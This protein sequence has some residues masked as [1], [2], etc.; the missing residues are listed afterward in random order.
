MVMLVAGGLQAQTFTSTKNPR[1]DTAWV[2]G[3]AFANMGLGFL[4]DGRM[5]ILGASIQSSGQVMGQGVITPADGNQALYITNTPLS[6]SGSLTGVTVTKILDSLTGPPP[7][8]VVVNDTVYVQDRTAFYRVISLN[9][10]G[11]TAKSKNAVRIINAPTLD[12]TFV[13]LRGESGHQYV[14]SPVY[15]NGRFYGA[16]S[17]SIKTGGQSDAPPTS[18]YSGTLLSWAKDSIVPINAPANSGFRKDAGGIRSPNGMASNGEYFVLT[19]NQ[20]SFNP[21]T[22]LRLFKP[23]QPLVTYGTRQSTT[24]NAGGAGAITNTLRNWAEDLPYQ[25]PLVWIPYDPLKSAAQPVYLNYGPYK[26]HWLVTDVNANGMGRLFVDNVGGGNY[27]GS[28]TMFSGTNTNGSK[29][30]NRMVVS[31]DSALYMGTML[32]IGNWPSGATSPVIRLSMKD[33][34]VFEILSVRS[35]KSVSGDTNGIEIFFSQPVDPTTITNSS[36][37]LQQQNYSLGANYGC[38]STVCTNKSPTVTSI[39]YS[40]DKRKVFVAIATPDTTIGAAHIGTIGVGNNPKGVWGG[41]GAQDRTLR[42]SLASGVRS[43]SGLAPFYLSAWMG[44]HF[45]STVR[46]D[47]NNTDVTPSPTSILAQKPEVARLASAVSLQSISGVLNVRVDLPGA[48]T[49]SIYTVSGALKAQQSGTTG[50]F[51]FDTRTYGRGMHIVRVKTATAAYSRALL[52]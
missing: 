27:Q 14:F 41:P 32:S 35:R 12:S 18:T 11:G 24:A 44:W 45:Q 49:V 4:S 42:V 31:P 50:A 3:T 51:R 20:G 23:G 6:R 29:A 8:L 48:A 19:D 43:A 25:P 33:T 46:F 37:S 22:P 15:H 36:F 13:W 16:Y 10:T 47:P 38:N 2:A 1:V 21:G 34:T 7:G 9:P 17:G 39:T 30:V 26:G 52:F 5:L 40:T 28:F